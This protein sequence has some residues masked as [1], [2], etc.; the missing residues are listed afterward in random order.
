MK[1]FADSFLLKEIDDIREKH[2]L[3]LVLTVTSNSHDVRPQA[4][5]MYY[6]WQFL[7]QRSG[8]L[9]EILNFIK[10][11]TTTPVTHTVTKKKHR[12]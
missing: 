9:G 1:C 5:E 11:I 6:H 3:N 2:L 4:Y 10:C 7:M 12:K 8:K